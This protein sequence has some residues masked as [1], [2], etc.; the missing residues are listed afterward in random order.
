MSRVEGRQI[1]SLRQF[2]RILLLNYNIPVFGIRDADT[3]GVGLLLV[4]LRDSDRMN[5][6]NDELTIPNMKLIGMRIDDCQ[7]VWDVME[8]LERVETQQPLH[9]NMI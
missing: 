6:M 4:Y 9:G 3:H 8:P 2:L 1:M 5:Y 7:G